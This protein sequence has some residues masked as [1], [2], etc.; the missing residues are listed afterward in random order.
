MTI[1]GLDLQNTIEIWL[2]GCV[3]TGL[4]EGFV[5]GFW[6]A[7]KEHKEKETNKNA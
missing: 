5:R 7:Y 4:A 3:C 1:F 6:K 2:L